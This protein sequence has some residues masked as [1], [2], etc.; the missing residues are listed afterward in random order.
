MKVEKFFSF[1][2][3]YFRDNLN[4]SEKPLFFGINL[5]SKETLRNLSRLDYV[6]CS[7]LVD[8]LD[9]SFAFSVYDI[10]KCIY[11]SNFRLSDELSN[12]GIFLPPSKNIVLFWDVQYCGNDIF[13]L[14]VKFVYEIDD[15]KCV[16]DD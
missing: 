16:S 2:Y 9:N 13:N 7:F 3:R 5:L 8:H 6:S 14:I 15:V 10:I 4:E 12:I 11:M 1:P